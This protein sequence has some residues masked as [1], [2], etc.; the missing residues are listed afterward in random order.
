MAQEAEQP[1]EQRVLLEGW[2]EVI[3]P[4]SGKPYYYHVTT[5]TTTWIRPELNTAAERP[6]LPLPP[7][8]GKKPEKK[9]KKKKKKKGEYVQ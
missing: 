7:P 3:D 5:R 6:V 4:R 1:Q 8:K 9:K 2:Q